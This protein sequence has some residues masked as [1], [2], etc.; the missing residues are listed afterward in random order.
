M[1]IFLIWVLIIL[2]CSVLVALLGV[3]LLRWLD[4]LEA[5]DLWLNEAAGDESISIWLRQ[6]WQIIRSGKF[7]MRKISAQ[8]KTD[9]DQAQG[10][11]VDQVDT[12]AQNESGERL[13]PN[14]LTSN[15]RL[16]VEIPI[17]ARIQITIETVPD[18]ADE[19]VVDVRTEPES[20]LARVKVQ[21]I[22]TGAA[23]VEP[24][25][26]SIKP[27]AAKQDWAARQAKTVA[28]LQKIPLSP[29]LFGL[30][31]FV[32]LATR[33]VGLD[34]F[35][36]YFF[37][38]ESIH[39]ILAQDLV[40]NHFQYNGQFLPTYFSMGSSFGLNSV[41][42]YL[43]VIPYL[44]FG[45]SVFVTRGVSVLISLL[46]AGAVG[47]ILKDFFKSR[48][49][50]AGV[51]I[52]SIIPT[53]FLHSRTAFESI[54]LASFYAVF[55]YFYLGYRLRS[56][57]YLFFAII[58]GALVFYTH[59]LGQFL[60]AV[61]AIL[62]F[63][64]DLPYHWKQRKIVLFGLLLIG[65]MA[66]PYFRFSH[67]NSS[68]FIEELRT[69]GS[70]WLDKNLNLAEKSGRFFSEYLSGF[71]PKYWFL[72][73]NPRDL[74]RHQMKGYGHISIL[75]LPFFVA[76]LWLAIKNIRL[77]AHRTV[78]IA[79]LAAPFGAATAQIT[80]LR[81]IWF[82]IPAA[83]LI[84]LGLEALLDWLEK[85]RISQRVLEISVF[86]ILVGINLFMLQDVLRNGPV[87]Y[88]DYSLYGMQYGAEQLFGQAIPQTL[89]QEPNANFVVT[90]TWANGT[91]NFVRFFLN[92]DQQSHVRLDSIQAYLFKR[93]P[94]QDNTYIVLTQPEYEQAKASPKFRDVNPQKIIYY[95]DGT[96]GF[97]FVRLAYS[98]SAD[99]I[100]AAEKIARS[101]P[102][103]GEV[104][105]GEETAKILYSQI[106][107][108]GP[109]SIFDGDTY[110]LMRGL[111]AN[112]FIIELDFPEPRPIQQISA[113]F[114][115]MDFT[116][117][118]ELSDANGDSVTYTTTQQNVQG[119]PH[120]EMII[121]R[122]PDLV[123]KLR[124]E[125]LSLNG[126]EQPHIHI[127]ELKLTP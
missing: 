116:L 12:Q 115:N 34:R 65:I 109:Q 90:P 95:P 50:W 113:D 120:V 36:I 121:D 44:L 125:I 91:D 1:G 100:F 123:S 31:L 6:R 68:V 53:W 58:A 83:L 88:K 73:D 80:I 38:D 9:V 29:V 52:L 117:T 110:T 62:L 55:L 8:E 24:K 45:K 41:S 82:V 48:Y 97:Y 92:P 64:V 102:V 126:G 122:G 118:V 25:P 77:P 79:L 16:S 54:E 2:L 49:W 94:I 4:R 124:M 35:P 47:L 105:I 27:M 28:W 98:D 85:R 46:G 127:R 108:G 107:M 63:L 57:Y 18:T 86:V 7:H 75:A 111:E 61:T 26:K 72:P 23:R 87:W 43:Q 60:M 66:I 67:A 69:R 84:S 14:G 37:T 71:N 32:Y 19:P 114:A 40:N 81:V 17:G 42:V 56:P 10:G 15:V 20:D 99:Q 103:E 93:L 112:P 74:I 78:L 22:S 51:F 70:Y 11:I 76:G 106:D 21:V 13:L 3:K 33:L 96:P 59:G 104:Q 119:N 39:T 30:A 101:Q 89:Q 5:D